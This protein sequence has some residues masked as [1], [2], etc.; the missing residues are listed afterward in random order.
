[1][2]KSHGSYFSGIRISS[3]EAFVLELVLDNL[4]KTPTFASKVMR[5]VAA[6]LRELNLK[7]YDG[8]L[9]CDQTPLMSSIDDDRYTEKKNLRAV[10]SHSQPQPSHQ[11]KSFYSENLYESGDANL[12]NFRDEF[13]KESKT[14]TD[15][16]LEAINCD[17]TKSCTE[18]SSKLSKKE[19]KKLR[20]EARNLT[21]TL[22]PLP[23]VKEEIEDSEEEIVKTEEPSVAP[24]PNLPR[25]RDKSV[26]SFPDNSNSK[27]EWL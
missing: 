2:R 24:F 22:E 23:Q 19:R 4:G 14:L 27:R 15:K 9:G 1:M 18:E 6:R 3:S 10:D 17:Y 26:A 12:I 16:K 13:Q 21:K 20:K 8:T 25:P 11:K 7:D 5:D